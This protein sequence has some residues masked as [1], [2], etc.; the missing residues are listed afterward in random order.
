M[1]NKI[2]SSKNQDVLDNKEFLLDMVDKMGDE[3]EMTGVFE[4]IKNNEN[5][6]ELQK[7]ILLYIYMTFI[8]AFHE[9]AIEQKSYEQLVGQVKLTRF[10][11]KTSLA[12]I[13]MR[14]GVGAG[15]GSVIPGFGTL[16]GAAAGVVVGMVTFS[17]RKTSYTEDAS[18][19]GLKNYTMIE[20]GI[21]AENHEELLE[22]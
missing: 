22:S 4:L 7:K 2:T 6:P 15:L 14:T 19:K 11:L 5:D 18:G 13:L 8:D 12:N 10:G 3:M 21:G 16:V 20:R 9:N 17:T 1:R